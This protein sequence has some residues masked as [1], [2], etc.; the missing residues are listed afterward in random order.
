MFNLIMQCML[1]VVVVTLSILSIIR[2]CKKE[3]EEA[4]YLAVMGF[5]IFE[6]LV[7]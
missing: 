6:I 1:M 2:F 3:T 7:K 5:L 4:M